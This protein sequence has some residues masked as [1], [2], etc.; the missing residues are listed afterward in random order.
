MQNKITFRS[1]HWQLYSFC[2]PKRPD[3]NSTSELTN[4]RYEATH[5]IIN[6]DNTLHTDTSNRT[7]SIFENSTH[8][9]KPTFSVTKW[10]KVLY[11]I[12]LWLLLVL[13]ALAMFIITR[14]WDFKGSHDWENWVNSSELFE[15]STILVLLAPSFVQP[16]PF[17]NMSHVTW[18]SWSKWW[19]QWDHTVWY[20]C[21]KSCWIAQVQIR[22][23]RI[24]NSNLSQK[25]IPF[26]FK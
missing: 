26:C 22:Y 1:H 8:H 10:K 25:I 20:V 5:F 13:I 9:P 12:G 15:I 2:I 21:L 3:D 17:S 18:P 11:I 23:Y 24:D 19:E 4:H 7:N 14:G 16:N 6:G